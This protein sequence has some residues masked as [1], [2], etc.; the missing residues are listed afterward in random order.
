[1]QGTLFPLNQFESERD[2]CAGKHHGNE[3]SREAWQRVRPSVADS[4]EAV[5]DAI[6]RAGVHG[7]TCKEVSDMLGKGMNACSGRFTELVQR[8]R[9]ERNHQR[10]DGCAVYVVMERQSI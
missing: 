7:A 10:R 8:G 6:L 1:M 9:I 5:Y 2:P 4:R 3:Q